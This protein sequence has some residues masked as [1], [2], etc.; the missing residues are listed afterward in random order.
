V[1]TSIFV[2]SR[3]SWTNYMCVIVPVTLHYFV[4]VLEKQKPVALHEILRV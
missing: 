4:E 3:Q 1:R 2:L